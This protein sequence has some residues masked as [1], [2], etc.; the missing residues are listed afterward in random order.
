MNAERKGF[1]P[2][3]ETL[4]PS[5]IERPVDMGGEKALGV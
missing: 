3:K 2:L 4:T 5:I 1:Y